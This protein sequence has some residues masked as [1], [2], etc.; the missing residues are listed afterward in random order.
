MKGT[1]KR[2]AL[3]GALALIALVVISCATGP[4]PPQPGTPAF[5]WGAANE[6]FKAGDYLKTNDNL[7]QV[8]RSDN[9]FTAR[10]RP[11]EILVSAGL[12][13]GFMDLAENY[14]TGA[15]INRANP[16]PFRKQVNIFRGYA[17][18]A[19]LQFVEAF[20]RF[21]LLNKDANVVLAFGYPTGSAAIPQQIKRVTSGIFVPQAEME[22]IQ[23]DMLQ[24]GVLLAVSRAVGAADD[25]AK[26]LEVF[27]KGEVQ[28]PAPVF[29]LAMAK[30]LHEQS[31]L[32]STTKLDQPVR[33][34]LFCNEALAAL[35]LVPAS[36]ESKDLTGKV[37]KTLKK[38]KTT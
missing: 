14:E 24:R 16:T 18:N 1:P 21:R 11:L 32:Y 2:V 9:E 37:E 10:A 25:T 3:A 28:V 13:Q 31:Q 4:R 30:T 12:A 38:I 8:T 33:M 22:E 7:A 5:Y 15:R 29:Y 26:A 19:S 36:K 35:K 27:Q 23:K 20:H 17:S 6:M 34:Q